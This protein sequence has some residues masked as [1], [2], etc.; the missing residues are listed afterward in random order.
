MCVICV[1]TGGGNSGGRGCVQW[2]SSAANGEPLY[3]PP[4]SSGGAVVVH[5]GSSSIKSRSVTFIVLAAWWSQ[6]M[7]IRQ[8]WPATLP[9]VSCRALLRDKRVM[10]CTRYSLVHHPT[11]AWQCGWQCI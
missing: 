9:T 3:L 2:R 7:L 10:C 4:A 1:W 5:Q 11:P 8:A 6:Q